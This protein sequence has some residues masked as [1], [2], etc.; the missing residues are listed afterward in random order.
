MTTVSLSDAARDW[1]AGRDAEMTLRLSARH[2]CCGGQAGVPV[3][4]P[5][6]PRSTEGYARTQIEGIHV[7]VAEDMGPGPY[8]VDL[9]GFFR[10]R[11]LVVEGEMGQVQE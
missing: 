2:G 3:A 8:R 1:L 5:G 9:E 7:Y 4:E 6:A 10:W 11:R